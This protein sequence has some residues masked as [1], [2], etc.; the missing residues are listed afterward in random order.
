MYALF[1]KIILLTAS[2]CQLSKK[3]KKK[4][5]STKLGCSLVTQIVIEGNVREAERKLT[6]TNDK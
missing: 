1:L 6:S 3:R 4:N 2:P 5:T